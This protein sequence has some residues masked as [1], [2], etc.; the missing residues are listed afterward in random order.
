MAK[1]PQRYDSAVYYRKKLM[2]RCTVSDGEAFVALM[3]ACGNCAARV[4]REYA[5]FS[6]ELSAILEKVAAIQQK[7]CA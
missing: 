2:G 1:K 7:E 4:L 3:E 5:Y 6:P